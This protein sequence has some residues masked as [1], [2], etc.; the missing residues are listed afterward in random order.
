MLADTNQVSTATF[1]DQRK[2]IEQHLYNEMVTVP[3]QRLGMTFEGIHC[4]KKQFT[5]IGHDE[6][7]TQCVGRPGFHTEEEIEIT[8]L[9]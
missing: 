9:Q 5:K 6:I 1:R 3:L 8:Y 7:S 2:I 4:I